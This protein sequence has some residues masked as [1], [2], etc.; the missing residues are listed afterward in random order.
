VGRLFVQ[1]ALL[2]VVALVGGPTELAY[3][4]QVRAAANAC[5]DVFPAA[6]PRPQA[7]WIDAKSEEAFRAFGL[8][9]AEA[10]EG[11]EPAAPAAPSTTRELEGA[12]A[13]LREHLRERMR[14][15]PDYGKSARDAEEAL[16]AAEKNWRKVLE[17]KGGRDLSRFR[18]AAT[19][20]RPKGEPQERV[21]SPVSLIA[22][23][24]LPAVREG[25]AALDPLAGGHQVVHA[26]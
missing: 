1:D 25:L 18:R 21:L 26:E 23:L 17:E 4:A 20:V 3:W 8:G 19:F 14:A 13:T 7:T 15:Q 16:D 6:A 9:V 24:G 22:R 12:L 10:V 11:A 2:P 5:G